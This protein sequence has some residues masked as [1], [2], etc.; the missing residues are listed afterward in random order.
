MRRLSMNDHAQRT[1]R[2]DWLTLTADILR[3]S[4]IMQQLGEQRMKRAVSQLPVRPL[5]ID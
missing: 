4:A 2:Y 5:G 1:R 3:G